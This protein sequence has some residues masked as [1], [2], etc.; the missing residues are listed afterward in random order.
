MIPD[1]THEHWTLNALQYSVSAEV[2]AIPSQGLLGQEGTV[3]NASALVCSNCF[4]DSIHFLSRKLYMSRAPTLLIPVRI[5]HPSTSKAACGPEGTSH[6]MSGLRLPAPQ[7]PPMRSEQLQ[8]CIFK[9]PISPKNHIS[10][11]RIP[12]NVQ[13]NTSI[14][15]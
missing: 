10:L 7:P 8:E 5:D 13:T 15:Y 12:R 6:L 4:A 14:S 9:I 2:T 11:K 1:S 3:T